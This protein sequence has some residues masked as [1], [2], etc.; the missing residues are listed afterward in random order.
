MNVKSSDEI[1]PTSDQHP[2]HI[3]PMSKYKTSVEKQRHQL[4]QEPTTISAKATTPKFSHR[5]IV[6]QKRCQSKNN[7]MRQ[8]VVNQQIDNAHSQIVNHKKNKN[9][10][11]TN[12]H[13]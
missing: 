6:D 11:N 5:P 12:A 10:E 13:I 7:K 1:R 2:T 3:R 4:H 8:R 9:E